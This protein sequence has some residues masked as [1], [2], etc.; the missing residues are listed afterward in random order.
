MVGAG[1]SMVGASDSMVGAGDLNFKGAGCVAWDAGPTGG[2]IVRS[3]PSVKRC[4]EA[5][6][7]YGI[8]A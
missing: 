5:T 4:A 2:W 6:L 1:D 8:G 3:V 7:R